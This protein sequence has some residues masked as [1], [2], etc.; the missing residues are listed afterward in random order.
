MKLSNKELYEINGGLT[1]SAS[2]FSSMSSL[3]STVFEIGQTVG[4]SISR[5]ISGSTCSV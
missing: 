2:L 1:V 4:S 3:L 5:V